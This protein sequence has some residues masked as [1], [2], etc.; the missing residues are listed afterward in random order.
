MIQVV[1]F[2]NDNQRLSTSDEIYIEDV[3][4][5]IGLFAHASQVPARPPTAN[6]PGREIPLRGSHHFSDPLLFTGRKI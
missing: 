4:E 1:W 6:K 3:K 5:V 2:K